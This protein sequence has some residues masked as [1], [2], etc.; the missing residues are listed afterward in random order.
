MKKLFIPLAIIGVSLLLYGAVKVDKITGQYREDDSGSISS[1]AIK[2]AL[3]AASAENAGYLS[4]TDWSTFNGKSNFSGSYNDLSNKPTIP[5]VSDSNRSTGWTSTTQAP[6]LRAVEQAMAQYA[7]EW[8]LVERHTVTGS[9]ITSY[10][11]SGLDGDSDKKYKIVARII[12]GYAG[13]VS[14]GVQCKT[15]TTASNYPFQ[16]LRGVD[17]GVTSGRGTFSGFNFGYMVS[18][19]KLYTEQTIYATSG[20]FRPC[21]GFINYLNGTTAINVCAM[22]SWWL[23]SVDSIDQLKILGDQTGCLG[24][25]SVFELWKLAQ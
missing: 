7:G 17:T 13:A 10:T 24:V 8:Q 11:F 6:S 4:T 12:N 5:S 15:D 1:A 21:T 9:A 23:N 18:G 25:G 22:S 20:Q 2:S 16:Y 14:F 19:D 3:G